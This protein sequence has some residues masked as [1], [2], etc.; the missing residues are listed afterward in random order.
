MRLVNALEV[1]VCRGRGGG[2]EG[3]EN[4]CSETSCSLKHK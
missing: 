3:G 2:G 1:W 4:E